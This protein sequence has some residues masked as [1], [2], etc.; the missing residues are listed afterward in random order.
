MY[1]I[2]LL[3]IVDA[4]YNFLFVDIGTEGRAADGGIWKDTDIQDAIEKEDADI[5]R[6]L[7]LPNTDKPS[8]MFLV[9]DDAFPLGEHMMKPYRRRNLT[10]EQE[11][12]NYRLSRARRV[13]ENAFGILVQ[14]FRIFLTTIE[15]TPDHV[16]MMVSACACMHNYLRER[17]GNGY[18]PPESIDR[19]DDQHNLILGEW[20]RDVTL[21]GLRIG[22]H[23]NQS[24]EAKTWRDQ[25][26]DYFVSEAGSVPWQWRLVR[27]PF[28][29]Y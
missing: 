26:K 24:I 15:A 22:T 27:D 25:L 16:Q 14:K 29:R 8:P 17:I 13:A 5:P 6:R 23:R 7:N 18:I 28:R 19:E 1:S 11:I 21:E 3:A 2:I 12:F 20:R 9:G 10:E 4:N